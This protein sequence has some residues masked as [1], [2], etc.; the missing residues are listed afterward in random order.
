MDKAFLLQAIRELRDYRRA[1]CN[2]LRRLEAQKEHCLG[3]SERAERVEQM[4]AVVM[5]VAWRCFFG[6]GFLSSVRHGHLSVNSSARMGSRFSNAGITAS[7]KCRV[8][9]L[10]GF[11]ILET[12]WPSARPARANRR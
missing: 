7:I 2:K 6:P 3:C 11:P 4:R 8:C 1:V 9:E 12:E 5:K 10:A